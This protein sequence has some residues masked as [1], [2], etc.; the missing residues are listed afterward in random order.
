[1]C[2]FLAVFYFNLSHTKAE[3]NK[4]VTQTPCIGEM[5]KLSVKPNGMIPKK[6]FEVRILIED[7]LQI[8]TVQAAGIN[9][10]VPGE[11]VCEIDLSQMK[12]LAQYGIKTELLRNFVLFQGGKN[13]Y[14][15]TG[16]YDDNVYFERD[17]QDTIPDWGAP[18]VLEEVTFSEVNCSYKA[19]DVQ[20]HIEIIHPH[21]QDLLISLR[22]I[23]PIKE[24]YFFVNLPG[25]NINETYTMSNF[26]DYSIRN[27]WQLI[28]WDIS[29]GY[30][31]YLDKWWIRV[32][33]DP[34]YWVWGY[35]CYWFKE[36]NQNGFTGVLREEPIRRAKV[37]LYEASQ[38]S[39][40][41]L[42]TTYTW[43]DGYFYFNID[44]TADP[45]SDCTYKDIYI[46]SYAEDE[47]DIVKVVFP[48]PYYG[49][50]H[51]WNSITYQDWDPAEDG[52]LDLSMTPDTNEYY[53]NGFF[54][55]Y[56]SILSSVDYLWSYFL[57]PG[58]MV[59]CVWEPDYVPPYDSITHYMY[60]Y[61]H[62]SGY[63]KDRDEFDRDTQ[64]HEYFHF[65]QDD[66][67]S[68]M[69][70]C[71]P[72]EG[73]HSWHSSANPQV[74]WTEGS[75]GFF[76]CVVKGDSFYVDVDWRGQE[77]N[78]VW[79]LEEPTDGVVGDKSDGANAAI[80]WDI[81]DSNNDRADSLWAG[82]APIFDVIFNYM[83]YHHDSCNIYGF[84]SG[85]FAQGYNNGAALSRI[86]KEHIPGFTDVQEFTS[87]DFLPQKFALLQNYP[88]P[89]NPETIIEY[90]LPKGPRMVRLVIY[91]IL[92]QEVKTL[93]NEEKQAGIYKVFWD[94]TDDMGEKVASGIYLS[95]IE[96]GGFSEV[97]KMVLVK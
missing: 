71:G 67:Y 89:F 75:A 58:S 40:T 73:Q 9:C 7:S 51:S 11:M 87:S 54:T 10:E 31:G 43:D 97:K 61:I 19:T 46:V 14:P 64:R 82:I 6:M 17:V 69:N 34:D 91:N 41:L 78:M 28:G 49:Y 84:W 24:V 59:T 52:D 29:P 50:T 2:L 27:V 37:E 18:T 20:I 80:L 60:G 25:E 21:T 93:V 85:W 30:E 4:T 32:Y 39:D 42:G 72:A 45:D 92:G 38:E 79:N 66:S 88:N 3:G 8:K 63:W 47:Y 90:T 76:P 77:Y 68:H 15:V 83:G 86:F 35:L 12:N 48:Y 36:Y 5:H 22:A 70:T 81:Y 65:L 53:T 23:Y 26:W 44:D 16:P 13:P 1:M 94:G 57:W 95:R 96:I 74:A 62:I 55:I 33:Y 56:E